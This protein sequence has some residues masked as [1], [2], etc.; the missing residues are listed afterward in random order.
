MK[1]EK[2]LLFK[3]EQ[4]SLLPEQVGILEKKFPQG[5]DIMNVP[6]EGWTLKEQKQIADELMENEG[7]FI[8]LSPVPY[9]LKRLSFQQ[10]YGHGDNCVARNRPL[11]GHK[12][13]VLVFH[14]D[15]REK[16]VLPNGK[17]IQTVAKTGWVLV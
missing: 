14:N 8:F 3:N 12:T 9:L 1:N 10:G 7:T 17:I 16:T 5:Y 11:Y 15:N 2:V 6:A 13:N 4:H